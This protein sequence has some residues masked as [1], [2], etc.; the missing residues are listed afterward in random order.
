MPIQLTEAAVLACFENA[1]DQQDVLVALYRLVFPDW[2][3]IERLDGHPAVNDRTWTAI[4]RLFIEFDQAHHPNVL[5]GGLWLNS[6]FSSGHKLGDWEVS[7]ESVTAWPNTR[8]TLVRT[9]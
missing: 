3:D 6:G 5:A 9:P 8:Y 1:D 4:C 7:L 2:D